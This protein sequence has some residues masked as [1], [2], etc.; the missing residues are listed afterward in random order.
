MTAILDFSLNAMSNVISDH[1]TRSGI[2]ENPIVDTKIK[3]LLL[4][5]REWC[6]FK[7]CPLPNGGH[8]EFVQFSQI[9]QGYPLDIRQICV[10]NP[11]RV[12]NQSKKTLTAGAGYSLI[13][14]DY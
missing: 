5:C 8:L 14:A 7:V 13:A 10:I 6:Q 11:M 9:A 3:K 1:T 12:W 4:F 2:P